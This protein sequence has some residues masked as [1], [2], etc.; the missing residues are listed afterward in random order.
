MAC[1]TH[2]HTHIAGGLMPNVTFRLHKRSAAQGNVASLLAMGDA[3][4]YGS[5][6]ELDWRRASAIYYEVGPWVWHEMI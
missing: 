5:G 2:T 4:F 6:V 1:H 3:Y